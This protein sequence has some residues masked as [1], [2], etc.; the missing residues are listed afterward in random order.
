MCGDGNH[1]GFIADT[2]LTRRTLLATLSAVAA[3]SGMSFPAFAEDAGAQPVTEKD[4]SIKTADGNADAAL[5]TPAGKGK[6]PAVL[7][8]P[9]I[10]GLRP[11]FREMGKRL[12]AQG[13]V[14]LVVNP[15]YRSKKAPVIEGPF[16]FGKPDDRS[17]LMVFRDALTDEMVDRDSVAYVD[18]LDAQ[19]QTDK[20]KKAA[21]Q[22]YCMSG[23]LS[24]HTAAVRADRIGAVATFH[25]GALVTD[26]PSSPHLLI[27]RSKASYLVIIA[28]NDAD[29]MPKEK[30]DLEAAFAAA[31]RPATVQ[32]ST[33]NHGWT[34]AGSQSY[35]EA[36]AERAWAE[37]L[38]FYKKTLG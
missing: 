36:E 26:K 30:P 25:P 24:F 8:W 3:A 22:G 15:Y 4:V 16:D 13:Y 20:S 38:R 33:A 2:S 18:F 5:F 9:D 23:P 6:W 19:P 27:P 12:A 21:V 28:K 31:H 7:M 35:D 1:Q 37:L 17:K 10:L 14:V 34:V 32:I 29:R 11:V